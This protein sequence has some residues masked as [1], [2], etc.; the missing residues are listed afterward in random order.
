MKEASN[1]R[2]ND[3]EFISEVTRTVVIVKSFIPPILVPLLFRPLLEVLILLSISLEVLKDEQRQE[4]LIRE[5]CINNLGATS[6]LRGAWMIVAAFMLMI[7]VSLARI[8]RK[9]L[10]ESSKSFPATKV[11]ISFLDYLYGGDAAIVLPIVFLLC[12][13][14]Q[15]LRTDLSNF[16]L[17]LAGSF[18]T[19]GFA[20]FQLVVVSWISEKSISI[21]TSFLS[22]DEQEEWLGDL[23]EIQHRMI[24]VEKRSQWSVCIFTL[25]TYA[26]FGA[27]KV[28]N[29]LSN[30]WFRIIGS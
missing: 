20:I 18:I 17:V 4:I 28:Q 14:F 16:W 21:L 8:T 30:I 23:R 22:T 11:G 5:N 6:K 7:W 29:L 24:H 12:L 3:L 1:S 27:N 13:I 2:T 10:D 15:L 25:T 26:R 9:L 19:T